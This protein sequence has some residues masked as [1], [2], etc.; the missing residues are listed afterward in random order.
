MGYISF[1]FLYFALQS[2]LFWT[3]VFTTR[4]KR[5]AKIMNKHYIIYYSGSY[6]YKFSKFT[7]I[8]L[9]DAYLGFR[10]P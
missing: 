1:L 4:P 3:E 8:R 5:F 7:V 6:A 9:L 2:T 10:M